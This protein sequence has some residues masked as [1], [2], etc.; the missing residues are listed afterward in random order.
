MRLDV[1]LLPD[2]RDLALGID[3]VRDALG[4]AF[5]RRVRRT[6]GEPDLAIRVAQQAK[7]EI[8]LLGEAAVLFGRVEAD[9]EDLDV[10]ASELGGLIAEPATLD[11][12]TGGVGL[13][14]EPEDDVVSSE[15]GEAHGR[16][17]VIGDFE[18]GGG[19]ADGQHGGSLAARGLPAGCGSCHALLR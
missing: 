4:I 19:C 17:G 6:V 15:V 13:W 12:S 8:E 5:G 2:L 7:R 1:D 14:I 11:R 18:I 3:E 9:A 16:A 10:F